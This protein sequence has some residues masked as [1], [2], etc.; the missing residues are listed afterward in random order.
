MLKETPESV[1]AIVSLFALYTIM[2]ATL[3][4]GLGAVYDITGGILIFL[5]GLGYAYTA[6]R[7]YSLLKSSPKNIRVILNFSLGFVGVFVV[8]RLFHGSDTS[9]IIGFAIAFFGTFFVQQ[10]VDAYARKPLISPSEER[11]G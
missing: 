7:W 2:L 10:G 9:V 1:R 5:P 3:Q 4:F 11:K 6:I 8:Y